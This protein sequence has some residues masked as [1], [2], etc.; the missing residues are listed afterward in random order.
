[1][2][3]VLSLANQW[4]KLNSDLQGLELTNPKQLEKAAADL[5]GF[6]TFLCDEKIRVVAKLKSLGVDTAENFI[7]RVQALVAKGLA[8]E[9]RRLY[10]E[11]GEPAKVR[12]LKVKLDMLNQMGESLARYER[13]MRLIH[14]SQKLEMKLSSEGH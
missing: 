3:K 12:E 10:I 11:L 13:L 7:K 9:E 6:L 8:Y 2:E 1:M 4:K 5:L 14:D